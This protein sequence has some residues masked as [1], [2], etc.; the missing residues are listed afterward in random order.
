MLPKLSKA[1][2]LGILWVTRLF[3]PLESLAIHGGNDINKT[4]T[5]HRKGGVKAPSFLTGFIKSNLCDMLVVYPKNRTMFDNP[6][7]GFQWTQSLSEI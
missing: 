2:L 4:S 3:T 6:L 7:V 1:A 5:P